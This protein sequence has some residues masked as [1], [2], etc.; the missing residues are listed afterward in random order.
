M[1]LHQCL[2]GLVATCLFAGLGS[3]APVNLLTNPGFETG[4]LTG[5]SVGGPCGGFGVSTDGTP[6]PGVTYYSL[7]PAYQNVR[8]GSYGAYAVTADSNRE[9][10]FFGQLVNLNPGAYT[11]SFYMGHDESG[12]IGISSVYSGSL[13]FWVDGVHQ[14][15][16]DN[17]AGNFYPG[18]TASDFTLFSAEFTSD[19]GPSFVEFRISGSGTA[20]AGISV[21]DFSLTGTGDLRMAAVQAPAP[22]A[23]LLGGLGTALI[24]WLRRSRTL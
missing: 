11:A 21:D 3:A 8:T 7:A 20:R 13:G 22:G 24:G 14:P 16:L 10:V 18:S 17:H 23:I 9:Y 5:W 2:I 15:F 19:G 1:K 4:D 12:P 6:I